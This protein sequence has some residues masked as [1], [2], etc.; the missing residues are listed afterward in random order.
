M[1]HCAA[2]RGHTKVLEFIVENVE[3][4]SLD[5]VDKVM[6]F[7]HNTFNVSLNKIRH[8]SIMSV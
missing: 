6:L 3:E 2:Q 7:Y 5:S 1:L 8:E 4:I